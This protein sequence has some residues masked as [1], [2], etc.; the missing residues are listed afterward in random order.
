MAGDYMPLY[1]QVWADDD[2]RHLTVAQQHAYCL[3]ASHPTI[4]YC[5]VLG[6]SLTRLVRSAADLNLMSLR[7]SV[8]DLEQ[9]RYLVCDPDTEEILV[10]S[11]IRHN[12]GLVKRGKPATAVSK[13]WRRIAS[14]R[15][16]AA[17]LVELRRLYTE[18][19]ELKGW[20][21]IQTGD[22]ELMGQVMTTQ[23]RP[24]P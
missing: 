2:W 21:F 9:R 23:I 10:R 22:Q 14:P 24:A 18:Q 17:V 20:Q 5:G 19:P 13:S 15:I 7:A 4:D 11:Y 8:H 12:L 3:I 1:T 16:A 6:C